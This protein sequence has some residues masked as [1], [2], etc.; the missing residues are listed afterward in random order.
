L[1]TPSSERD[2]P[3]NGESE[4]SGWTRY[5]I[6]DPPPLEIVDARITSAVRSKTYHSVSDAHRASIAL[7]VAG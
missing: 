2:A 7:A 6:G 1:R 4:A 5:T 3:T